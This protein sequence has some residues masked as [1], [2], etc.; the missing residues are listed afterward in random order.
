M[1]DAEVLACHAVEKVASD[2]VAWRVGNGVHKPVELV[3]VRA[4]LFEQG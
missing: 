4:E 2:R 3:P 1:R